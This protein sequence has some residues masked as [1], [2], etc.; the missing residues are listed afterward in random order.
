MTVRRS[1][2][3]DS[4]F[5]PCGDD[6]QLPQLSVGP[7]RKP[8]LCCPSGAWIWRRRRLKVRDSIG[9]G[10]GEQQLEVPYRR[11]QSDNPGLAAQPLWWSFVLV[12]SSFESKVNAARQHDHGC[13]GCP[14]YGG[15]SGVEDRRARRA[16]GKLQS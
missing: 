12:M 15:R 9:T 11:A 13:S 3:V 6:E 16:R 1:Q 14:N 10:G 8:E 7:R 2:S 5:V 4:D